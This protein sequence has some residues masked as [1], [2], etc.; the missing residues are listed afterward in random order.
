MKH[1]GL[2][3]AFVC[4]LFMSQPSA[5]CVIMTV[6]KGQDTVGKV[7]DEV[8][9]PGEGLDMLGRYNVKKDTFEGLDFDVALDSKRS[10][11]WAATFEVMAVAIRAGKQFLL[12]DFTKM[13]AVT[14]S[15]WCTNGKCSLDNIFLPELENKAG[16]K[17]AKLKSLTLY[18]IM[19][20]HPAVPEAKTWLMMIIGFCGTAM[21][22][23]RRKREAVLHH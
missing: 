21:L 15:V 17:F 16:T 4:F 18:G 2:L 13:D 12:L 14:S 7:N 5:A 6:H 11:D 8:Y 9:D 23:K 3:T 22:L 10:G 19:E 1:I 20:M